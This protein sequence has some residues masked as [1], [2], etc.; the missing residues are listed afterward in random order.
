MKSMRD[1]E[2]QLL[3]AGR[4]SGKTTFQSVLNRTN[5]YQSFNSKLDGVDLAKLDSSDKTAIYKKMNNNFESIQ[6][7]MKQTGANLVTA[8]IEAQN[9][10]N[11]A[12]TPSPTDTALIPLLAGKTKQELLESAYQSDAI[13][14]V[15]CG[16]A[17]VAVGLDAKS[18]DSLGAYAAPDAYAHLKEVESELE[19]LISL[20]GTFDQ[21]RIGE[22]T[23]LQPSD[24]QSKVAKALDD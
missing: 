9:R 24:T 4:L 22:Q 20:K 17:G 5:D 18:I 19:T 2:G 12:K 16:P 7:A 23:R 3:I 1:L 6:Q 8:Q 10:F 13:A 21:A 14:R 15:L 11:M